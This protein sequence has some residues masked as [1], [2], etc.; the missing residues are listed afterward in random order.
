LSCNIKSVSNYKK[1]KINIY[2]IIELLF[3]I[4]EIIKTKK[5]KKLA[6]DNKGANK[7]T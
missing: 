1:L 2:N 4:E 6:K 7:K 3:K 5:T